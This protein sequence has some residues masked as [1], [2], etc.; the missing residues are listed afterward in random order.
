MEHA[1]HGFH[2]I[3]F[4]SADVIVEM[5]C[6]GEHALHVFHMAYVPFFDSG[7]V[8]AVAVLEEKAHVRNALGVDV[9]KMYILRIAKSLE[10]VLILGMPDAVLGSLDLDQELCIYRQFLSIGSG[11]RQI[12]HIEMAVDFHDFFI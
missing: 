9:A 12:I 6:M 2:F 3:K 11:P 7:K 8:L 10:F 5:D 1:A 4:P